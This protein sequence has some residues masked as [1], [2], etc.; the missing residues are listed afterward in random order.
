MDIKTE[1]TQLHIISLTDAEIDRIIADPSEFVGDLIKSLPRVNGH[2]VSTVADLLGH[3]SAPAT[4]VYAKRAKK[5]KKTTVKKSNWATDG[6]AG[7]EPRGKKA[8]HAPKRVQERKPCPYGC[9]EMI[10]PSGVGPHS[11]KC[12]RFQLQ[13]AAAKAAAK[14]A[15]GSAD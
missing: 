10:K 13:K 11:R 8:T 2:P 12:A 9:G 7:H 3:A 1:T 5:V 6:Y 15:G 4:S 14:A